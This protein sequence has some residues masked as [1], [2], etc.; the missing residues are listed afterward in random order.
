MILGQRP[1]SKGLSETGER[2][3]QAKEGA[4]MKALSQDGTR[5]P[6]DAKRSLEGPEQE[7]NII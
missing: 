3:G 5:R 6:W 4:D 1:A 2:N 7:N